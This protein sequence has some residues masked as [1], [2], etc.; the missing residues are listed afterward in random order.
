MKMV[1]LE[2]RILKEEREGEVIINYFRLLLSFIYIVGVAFVSV[3]HHVDGYN[4]LPWRAHGGTSAFFIY[5]VLLF[6]YLRSRKV[7]PTRLKYFCVIMDMGL[8]SLSIFLTGTYPGEMLP[9][10]NLSIQALFYT[11][12]IVLGA[13][14]YNIPCAIFSGIY[15]AVLYLIVIA[16]QGGAID[17]PYTAVYRNAQHPVQFPLYMEVF[18]LMAFVLA[19][20]V[21]GMA[22][23][24]H[25]A[26]LKTMLQTEEAAAEAAS[27]TVTQTRG[28]AKTLRESTREIS[29]SSKEIFTT[30]NNQA[31][32]VQEIES[33]INENAQIAAA[34]SDKTGSVASIAVKMEEDV[35]HGFSVLESIVKKMGDIKEKNDGVISGIVSLGNKII[36]I[37]DIIKTINT[38]T[39]Q[40][41]VI[42]FNAALEAASAGDKGKRFA[43][44][45]SEVNRLADDIAALT[46]QIRD[47]VEEIQNSSSS[48][49]ISS[50]EGAD[51]ITEGYKLIKDLE[52]VFKEILSGAEITSN[53]AQAITVSTQKQ[54]LSIEQINVGIADISRGLSS[55]IHSTEIANASAEGLTRL[56]EELELVLNAEQDAAGGAAFPG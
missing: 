43:V 20:L 42:A 36:K 13:F 12:M 51:K 37:R 31:A 28:I 55:F 18:R 3:M 53:Q 1:S 39:D 19:G 38:I 16:I 40:T 10:A 56:S 52:D 14:R 2:D 11:F 45:A 23:K 6:F 15:A 49:I 35:N 29:V 44:V 32:S 9:I 48:L 33:T 7:L 22:C 4:Y 8:I 47:Q 25:Q 24:R 17:I 54:Q 21:T 27:K 50:E 26:L 41:K 34:I 30:A 46:K 5:S